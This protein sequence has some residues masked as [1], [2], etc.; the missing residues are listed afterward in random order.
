MTSD[1]WICGEIFGEKKKNAKNVSMF[2][3]SVRMSMFFGQTKDPDKQSHKIKTY[4]FW[5][6]ELELGLVS[7]EVKMVN[8]CVTAF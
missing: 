8:L 1:K 5:Q 6:P 2:D 4:M 7:N 3:V